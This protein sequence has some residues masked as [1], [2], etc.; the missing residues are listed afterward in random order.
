MLRG[1]EGDRHA[2]AVP[3]SRISKMVRGPWLTDLTTV[4]KTVDQTKNDH[5]TPTTCSGGCV[6]HTI[7]LAIPPP[8][9]PPPHILS[10][11]LPHWP[12][13]SSNASK[14]TPKQPSPTN[15]YPG[16]IPPF[17]VN[18]E[19][20]VTCPPPAPSKRQ[21]NQITGTPVPSP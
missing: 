11:T 13:M 18:C 1:Q 7:K 12:L 14:N 17:S 20:L 9:P 21:K 3:A 5:H 10:Y 4:K 15:V 6:Q 8:T 19:A 16:E 2:F